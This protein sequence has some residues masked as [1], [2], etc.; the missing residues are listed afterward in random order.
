MK[1]ETICLH[2]GSPEK[3]EEH[4]VLPRCHFGRRNNRWTV[5]LCNRCHDNFETGL[6]FLE[7]HIGN[8]GFGNRFKLHSSEYEKITKKFLKRKYVERSGAF[9]HTS[10]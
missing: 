7:S 2:C 9:F 1:M 10:S 5:T 4:H 6:L 3:L 8:V